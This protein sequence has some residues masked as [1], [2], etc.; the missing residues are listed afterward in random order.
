MVKLNTSTFWVITQ[1][2][3]I[4]DSPETL[5]LNQPTLPNKPEQFSST[6]CDLAFRVKL[7]LSGAS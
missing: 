6:A 5:V 4:L 2:T 1:R 7:L 3:F